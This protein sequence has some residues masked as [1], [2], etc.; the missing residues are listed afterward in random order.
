[1][2]VLH[3]Y[4]LRMKKCLNITTHGSQEHYLSEAKPKTRTKLLP[5]RPPCGIA[6]SYGILQQSSQSMFEQS[7]SSNPLLVLASPEHLLN[8]D[9]SAGVDFFDAACVYSAAVLSGKLT[10]ADATTCCGQDPGPQSNRYETQCRKG[11]AGFSK[12]W[13]RDQQANLSQDSSICA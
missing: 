7:C 2:L 6:A 4:R 12:Q 13:S 8:R 1:M 3:M 11:F 9:C 5:T 10:N